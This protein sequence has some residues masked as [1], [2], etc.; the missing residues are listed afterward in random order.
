MDRSDGPMC[1]L[2]VELDG[3]PLGP[4]NRVYFMAFDAAI[5]LGKGD[6]APPA[7]LEEGVFEVG[8]RAAELRDVAIE[9]RPQGGTARVAPGKDVAD[10]VGA[11]VA[12]VQSL[13]KGATELSAS[14]G[15]QDWTQNCGDGA[16]HSITQGGEI[17]WQ[18][19]SLGTYDSA[20]STGVVAVQPGPIHLIVSPNAEYSCDTAVWA[21]V[22]LR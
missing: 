5:D 12:S 19:P 11:G 6:V 16:T 17:L 21:D 13:R 20:V 7:Q 18:G 9:R 4:P 14:V 1:E 15:I 2:A 22:E 8:P 3:D 10:L